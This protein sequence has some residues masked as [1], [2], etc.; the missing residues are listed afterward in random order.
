MSNL[1]S[2]CLK[3]WFSGCSRVFRKVGCLTTLGGFRV[4]AHPERK[5]LAVRR[6]AISD[7]TRLAAHTGNAFGTDDL[8]DLSLGRHGCLH[9]L[10]TQYD[11]RSP[12]SERVF[13]GARGRGGVIGYPGV[14]NGACT[15]SLDS[16]D[17]SALPSKAK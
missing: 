15:D 11:L 13:L 10:T 3:G 6:G 14:E 4:L 2:P 12:V 9:T 5:E 16:E 1:L 7:E 8:E 17:L